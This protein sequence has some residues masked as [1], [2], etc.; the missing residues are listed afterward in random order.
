MK[1]LTPLFLPLVVLALSGCLEAVQEETHDGGPDSGIGGGT[2]GGGGGGG[3]G[4]GGG[5]V[6]GG[7]GQTGGGG[8][9]LGGGA[10]GGTGGGGGGGGDDGGLLFGLVRPDCAPN[11][12]PAF[13]FHLSD[14]PL[15]CDTPE[16]EGFYVS[17]WT[18]QMLPASYTLGPD[19]SQQGSA[20]L[21]GAIGD[22]SLVGSVM[23][24]D[25]ATDAGVTGRI[26]ATF[27]TGSQVHTN[28]QVIVCPG[29]GGFCG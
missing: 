19:F 24:I 9:G 26:D 7:G 8:G 10:G 14:V 23:R 16:S 2:G 4:T 21:C 28:W 11:D 20:C 17:L 15:S 25:T 27:Q 6:G 5:S 12:G 1:L 18:P 22:L 29:L 13:R 3:G